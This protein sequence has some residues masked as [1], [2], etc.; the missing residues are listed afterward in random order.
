MWRSDQE[1]ARKQIHTRSTRANTLRVVT[2]LK[3]TV[4][5]TNGELQTSFRR[6]GLRLALSAS[7]TT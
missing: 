7:F 1:E 4:D 3:K 6:A 2:S 5:T